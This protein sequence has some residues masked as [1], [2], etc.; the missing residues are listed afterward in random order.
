MEAA[1][2]KKALAEVLG[3][4]EIKVDLSGTLSFNVKDNEN[5]PVEPEPSTG[6]PI[7]PPID[8]PTDPEI[9]RIFLQD[10]TEVP[11]DSAYTLS[12]AIRDFGPSKYSNGLGWKDIYNVKIVDDNE[13]RLMRVKTHA[14]HISPDYGFQFHKVMTEEEK[15]DEIYFSY[16]IIFSPYF[17]PVLGGKL[18]GLMGG[19][20]PSG[21]GGTGFSSRMMFKQHCT[22]DF[23]TYWPD[24]TE[25]YG[26]HFGRYPD[27]ETG[28]T[29]SFYYD[30]EVWHNLTQRIVLNSAADKDDG[31]LEA[32]IDGKFV[33][34]VDNMRLRSDMS[35]KI[36]E[37]AMTHFFGGNTQ[38]WA[39]SK[40][41]WIK[42]D[43]VTL[44]EIVE[45]NGIP[46]P[47]GRDI[48]F[49]LPNWPKTN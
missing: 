17:E 44:F 4:L 7:E 36:E 9:N 23:Y 24:R 35:V 45:T 6:P 26:Q 22:L 21:G 32:F 37:M 20:S 31:F 8:P 47:D 28:E 49:A 25:P 3:S 1:D 5:P 13:T 41:Q 14:D 43:D 38:D 19:T 15:R 46:S 33:K 27:P 42:L 39:P 16:N 34:R 30:H 10:F 48:T 12:K 18:P 40:D 2:F 29:F 11:L